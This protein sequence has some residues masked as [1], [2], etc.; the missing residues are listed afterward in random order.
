MTESLLRRFLH[1]DN[2]PSFKGGNVE[3]EATGAM[4]GTAVKPKCHLFL[5]LKEVHRLKNKMTLVK[6]QMNCIGKLISRLVHNMI[7]GNQGGWKG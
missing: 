5:I 2:L 6:T 7:T 3:L 4:M 1:L